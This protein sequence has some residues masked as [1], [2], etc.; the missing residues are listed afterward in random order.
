MTVAQEAKARLYR[1]LGYRLAGMV[2]VNLTVVR[3][4]KSG[5]KGF[6]VQVI[7]RTGRRLR[8]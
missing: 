1:E 2:G 8:R 4:L 7:S 5:C 6:C 3:P